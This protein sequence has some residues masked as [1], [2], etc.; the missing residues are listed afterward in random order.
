MLGYWRS[1]RGSGDPP[2]NQVGPNCFQDHGLRFRD[3]GEQG[4]AMASAVGFDLRLSRLKLREML[5][6]QFLSPSVL[7]IIARGE[8]APETGRL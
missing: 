6:R 5:D 1:H 4:V 8:V 2:G 7:I 3:P